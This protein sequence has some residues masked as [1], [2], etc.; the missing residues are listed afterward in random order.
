MTTQA[1]KTAAHLRKY[2]EKEEFWRQYGKAGYYKERTD[3]VLSLIPSEIQSVI[4]L[5]T[6][7]GDIV[8]RLSSG[9]TV[10]GL[11]L[12]E[13]AL[14]HLQKPGIL[15]SISSLPLT[16]RSFDLV[17][18]LEVIEHMPPSDFERAIV[19][20][21]RV[22]KTWLLI[23]IPYRENLLERTVKCSK[24][25]RLFHADTHFR[26]FGSPS[27]LSGLFKQ[28]KMCEYHLFGPS[29]PRKLVWI[30]EL[31]HKLGQFVPW[32]SFFVCPFCGNNEA[33]E[34]VLHYRRMVRVL[35]LFERLLLKTRTSLPF[36][37]IGLFKRAE[38][39]ARTLV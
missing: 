2:W 3:F 4:D 16:D 15:G 28:F 24:C 14:K 5:G 11:D 36:W 33:P 18:C 6:G 32:E 17:I 10:A 27:E 21:E 1:Q 39:E 12:S 22:A 9:M 35:E 23:G 19:E 34:K 26:R 20:L 31:K 13:V 38:Q 7:T 37:L 29:G 8:N 30:E 25:N